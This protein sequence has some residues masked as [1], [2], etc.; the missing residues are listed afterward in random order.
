[1]IRFDRLKLHNYRCFEDCEVRFE[2]DLTVFVARNGQ[3][4]TAI[5]DAVALALGLFVDT[6]SGTATWGGFKKRDIRRVRE[7]EKTVTSTGFVQFEAEAEIAGHNLSWRRWM[8][9]DAK[10]ERTSKSDAKPL[11]GASQEIHTRLAGKD[12]G[13]DLVLPLIAYYGTGRRWQNGDEK[14]AGR[15]LKVVNERCLGYADCLSGTA[16]YSLFVNWYENT[17][18]SLSERT[19]VTGIFKANRPEF[20]LAAVNRAVDNVL[21]PET[22]W[23]GLRWDLA[24]RQLVLEHPVHGHL[25]MDYLS[26]G[27]RNTAALV[28]DVAHRC[29]RLNPQLEDAAKNTPGVLLIDEVD[30]HLHPE[31]QQRIVEMLQSAFPKLQLILTTHSPQVLSTVFVK[32]IRV[33]RF[34][35]GQMGI[36]EKD[37]QTRGVESVDA[38]RE[39]MSVNP[40]P[41]VPEA[42]WLNKYR[43]LIEEGRD[44]S[45]EAQAL[46]AKLLDH[47][48]ERHPLILDCDRLARFVRFK[49]KRVDGED[50]KNA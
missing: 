20:L 29:A 25:P 32:Q 41:D 28:A 4:K 31:W 2:P 11:I 6:V 43:A 34:A 30:L 8:R 45:E 16:S 38:L 46:R 15:A 35:D 10:Q 13:G 36:R 14:L 5:L 26:D 17:F 24:S 47:F 33:V 1:M 42:T 44:E 37:F 27:V 9:T 12:G 50:A 7:A 3:G 49:K 48:G 23:E 19:P 40:A 22:G 21:K 18:T 39:I